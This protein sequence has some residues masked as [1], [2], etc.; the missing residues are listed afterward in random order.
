MEG[1]ELLGMMIEYSG[2]G[3]L[4]SIFSFTTKLVIIEWLPFSI[5]GK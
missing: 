2:S 4:V 3:W 5:K 1:N